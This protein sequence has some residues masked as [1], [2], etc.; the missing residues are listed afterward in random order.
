MKHI[1]TPYLIE[2]LNGK[3]RKYNKNKM[4]FPSDDVVLESVFLA[5]REAAQKCSM[6]IRN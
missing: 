6:P 2:N 1:Y 3:A 4:P 5:L